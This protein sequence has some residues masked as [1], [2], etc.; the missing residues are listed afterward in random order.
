MNLFGSNKR[1]VVPTDTQNLLP[2]ENIQLEETSQSQQQKQN[3]LIFF[4]HQA[5][6]RCVLASFGILT[7]VANSCW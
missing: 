1:T 3:L 2:Q 7:L 4:T 6:M 5:R